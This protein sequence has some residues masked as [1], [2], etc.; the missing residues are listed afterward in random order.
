MALKY[1]FFDIEC[2]QVERKDYMFS[3]G[4]VLCDESFNVITQEDIL[5]NPG[6]NFLVSTGI[7]IYYPWN[8][9]IAEP[10]FFEM[11]QKLKELLE[12]PDH[13]IVGHAM[14]NDIKFLHQECQSYQLPGFDFEYVDSQIL[15]DDFHHSPQR[16]SIAKILSYYQ[17]IPTI[18]HR[19]DMDAYYNMLYVNRM[20]EELKLNLF[21]FTNHP[22]LIKG[23]SKGLS[24]QKCA[25]KHWI[26]QPTRIENK[27]T[28]LGMINLNQ[29]KIDSE[30]L[31]G[32]RFVI[33][34]RLLYDNLDIGLFLISVILKYGG[35]WEQS[36]PNPD[37]FVYEENDCKRQ[38][39]LQTS[40]SWTG[41]FLTIEE[42]FESLSIDDKNYKNQSKNY[43]E[44]TLKN[45]INT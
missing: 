20:A 26:D 2:I 9:I 16:S 18:L 23:S 29:F 24:L 43:F 13:I 11:Y 21:A 37:I 4:Y 42:L 6:M 40:P 39:K 27:L 10:K 36:D 30:V 15:F 33:N 41:V 28:L 1:L 19:S 8:K 44:I 35:S 5:I 17:I 34:S 7:K 38:E 22:S 14:E 32:K 12:D 45:Q 31:K 25:L 3:F